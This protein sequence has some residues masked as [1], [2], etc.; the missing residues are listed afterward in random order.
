[1]IGLFDAVTLARTKLRTKRIRQII[2]IVVSSLVFGLSLGSI[3]VV[4]GIARSIDRYAAAQFDGKFFVSTQ[5]AAP[6]D[7][8]E[9]V[10]S[11]PEVITAVKKLHQRYVDKRKAAAQRLGIAYDPEEEENAIIPAAKTEER[12]VINTDSVAY[13]LYRQQN[14]TEQDKKRRVHNSQAF[15]EKLSDGYAAEK[16]ESIDTATLLLRYMPD[17]KESFEREP[18]SA[19][20]PSLGDFEQQAG[21]EALQYQR[22]DQ[23]L[24]ETYIAEPNER[25]QQAGDAIPVVLPVDAAIKTFGK[26]Y[27][28]PERPKDSSQLID[29]YRTLSE[30]L[31]GR[32]YETCYR[33][34]QSLAQIEE[35]LPAK[36]DDTV[37]T[38]YRLPDP[39]SCGAAEL[40]DQSMAEEARTREQFERETNP[41]YQPAA[42][43]KVRF[44]IVGVTPMSFHQIAS[45]G[46]EGLVAS[47]VGVTDL[48]SA[49]I[50][51]AMYRA[52]P[53]EKR[54]ESILFDSQESAYEMNE[55]ARQSST[56]R[57]GSRADAAR[58]ITEQSCQNDGLWIEKCPDDRPLILSAYG[59]NYMAIREFSEFTRPIFMTIFII[60]ATVA[61][62]IIM[63][64]MGRVM[65]ENRRETAVFRAIGATRLDIAK[66]YLL[67]ALATA[68]C[69]ALFACL[70]GLMIS[71]TL[72]ILYA[73]RATDYA[74]LAF[75]VLDQNIG[76]HFVAI[77]L[78]AWFILAGVVAL[79]VIGVLPALLRNL[80]R[81]PISDMRDE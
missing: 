22:I 17:G 42:Q 29:W 1:M 37:Q 35:A 62:I 5:E 69:I 71:G 30:K 10:T 55:Y 66:V 19:E 25:R 34:P 43:Q 67:Y 75:G 18:A 64:M 33:N 32:T 38:R 61:G 68:I 54:H 16:I 8:G 15:I 78:V 73:A 57:F 31:N 6:I 4:D 20:Q 79:G 77:P 39:T 11:D 26:T 40:V 81:N 48:N 13:R 14:P 21:I 2:T 24:L 56:V 49:K 74:Q 60:L 50:P 53:Q 41:F 12:E 47:F 70:L 23:A 7:F 9:D 51:D 36:S 80:R 44:V 58:F 27:D 45:G 52:L 46:L 76:F 72:E 63:A 3:F 59:T 28:L 65:A